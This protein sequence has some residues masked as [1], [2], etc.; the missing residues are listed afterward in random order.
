MVI[1]ARDES[2]K[3]KTIRGLASHNKQLGSED[4]QKTS[5]ISI[6]RD[7]VFSFRPMTYVP[8]VFPECA[9]PVGIER[10]VVPNEAFSASSWYDVDHEPWLARLYSREGE[11]AWCALESDGTQ[12]L[13]IDL[14][15]IHIITGVA[16]QGKNEI[17]E[18]AI[19]FRAWVRNFSLSFTDDHMLWVNYTEDGVS[20]KVSFAKKLSL[21]SKLHTK[22]YWSNYQL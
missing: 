2:L 10:G 3:S 15:Q 7:H 17:S 13:Q 6:L 9:Y 19:R 1:I 11:G 22:P 16:T 4:S 5:N 20:P 18:W 21:D 12:Y 14:A 8:H